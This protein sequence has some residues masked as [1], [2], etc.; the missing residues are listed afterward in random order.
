MQRH[1][2]AFRALDAHAGARGLA[3]AAAP[4]LLA[5]ARADAASHAH[6]LLARAR[7][8]GEFSE[9]HGRESQKLLLADD[10]DEV[11][12]FR[13]HP[14]NFGRISELADAPDL[15]ELEPEQR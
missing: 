2:A 12:H 11:L 9:P 13:D 1:L 7:V 8:G 3:L 4:R 6:T 14:A 15:V 5:L 10:A